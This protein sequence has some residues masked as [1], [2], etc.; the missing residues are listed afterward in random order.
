MPI[1]ALVKLALSLGLEIWLLALLV[2]REVR[3]H[4]PVFFAYCVCVLGITV[5]RLAS[6][7]RYR[8]YFYLF[9]WTEAVLVPLSLMALNEVF[10]WVYR[11]FYSLAWFRVLYFGVIGL[12]LA[13]AVRNALVNP[14]VQAHPLLGLILN[15]GIA[16]NFLQVGIAA[17]FGALARPLG[18]PFR[19]YPFGIVAGLGLSAM[20]P[21]VGYLA[22]S[23]F[24]NKLDLFTQNAS[25]MA[26]ILA[27]VVWLAAF[28]RSEPEETAWVPPMAPDEM[29]RIVRG[30]LRAMGVRNVK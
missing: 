3:R 5:L 15:I 26:Y 6:S 23:I 17:L 25:A 16:F 27:L 19:R 13:I 12:V 30:Y 8:T 10:R 18:V 1:L 29:L 28:S 24:G 4:F 22:R 21:F 20:G 2:R 11:G 14:P 9:W 7:G